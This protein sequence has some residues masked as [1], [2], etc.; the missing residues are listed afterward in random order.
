MNSDVPQ[1]GCVCFYFLLVGVMAGD[2]VLTLDADVVV[3]DESYL[4]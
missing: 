1:D 4:G 3:G 2:F